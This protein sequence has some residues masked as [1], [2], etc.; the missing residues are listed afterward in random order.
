MT[1]ALT[2]PLLFYTNIGQAGAEKD[3]LPPLIM[4]LLAMA[5]VDPIQY[6]A[7]LASRPDTRR[8]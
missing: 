4:S 7:L 8:H 1:R 6:T 5:R 2:G 3:Y